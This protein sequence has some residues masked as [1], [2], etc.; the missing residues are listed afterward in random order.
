MPTP[1]LAG[2]RRYTNTPESVPAATLPSGYAAAEKLI[3]RVCGPRRPVLADRLLDVLC[4]S[5]FQG[6]PALEYLAECLLWYLAGRDVVPVA[7]K[8]KPHEADAVKARARAACIALLADAESYSAPVACERL[9]LDPSD[10][11]PL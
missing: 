10:H 6:A 2:R 5:G 8:L 11:L 4:T 7:S 3:R 9:N 1:K